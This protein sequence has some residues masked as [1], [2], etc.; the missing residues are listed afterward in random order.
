[1]KRGDIYHVDLDPSVGHEQ[2]GRRSVLVVSPEAFNR[3]SIP[4]VCPISSGGE[5]ARVKG[6]TVALTGA[7]TKTTGVILC[8]QMRALDLVGRKAKRIEAAPK[9]IVDEVMATIADILECC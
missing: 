4:F 9:E 3:I 2:R 1:M 5:W 6:F 7:G 8:Q